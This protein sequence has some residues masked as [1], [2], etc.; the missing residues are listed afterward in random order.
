MRCKSLHI[1]V[2]FGRQTANDLISID[3]PITNDIKTLDTRVN[4]VHDGKQ[5]DMITLTL[6]VYIENRFV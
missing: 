3:Q 6:T 5:T 4:Y 2:Y 1:V